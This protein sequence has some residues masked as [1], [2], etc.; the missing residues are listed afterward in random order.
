MR[1]AKVV[2]RRSGTNPGE[3]A[4][5]T[6]AVNGRQADGG[7]SGLLAGGAAAGDGPGAS[8]SAGQDGDLRSNS[9]SP[10]WT[11]PGYPAAP[12][13]NGGGSQA[14][15]AAASAAPSETPQ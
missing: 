5:A 12:G 9:P 15:P 11:S 6:G 8:V 1:G 4:G 10:Q 14:S 2:R 13:G 7:G 3:A